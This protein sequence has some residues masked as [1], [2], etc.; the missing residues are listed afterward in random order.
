MSGL[1]F[2]G[3]GHGQVQ[4]EPT[5]QDQDFSLDDALES[6]EIIDRLDDTTD[7]DDTT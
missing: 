1:A 6:L 7:L 4:E 2:A 5:V 3:C